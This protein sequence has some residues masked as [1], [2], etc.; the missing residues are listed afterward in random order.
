MV[1]KEAQRRSDATPARSASRM[2]A[3]GVLAVATSSVT[4]LENASAA[5][6]VDVL[7]FCSSC[8][9]AEGRSA[10]PEFP[11]LAGQQKDYIVAQLQNFR[12]DTRTAPHAQTFLDYT[13]MVG[14][15]TQLAPPTSDAVAAYYSSQQPV[16]GEPA[17]SPEIVLGKKI[18]TEGVPSDNVPACMSC[19]GVKA[20]GNG[21]TP[22][23]AGQY[24]T[25]LARQLEA[26]ASWARQNVTMH[27]LSM[28]LTPEQISEVTAYLATL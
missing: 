27:A 17:V 22:R 12:D 6:V 26:F 2:L 5:D 20:Q 19:H 28:N 24:R 9:G 4:A 18:Y 21:A 11:R 16:A 23:L 14:M 15:V 3:F 1:D 10:S 13:V 25:Y 8:H 7:R